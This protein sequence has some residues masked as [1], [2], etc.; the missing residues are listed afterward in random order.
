[1]L[2]GAF[3]HSALQELMWAWPRLMANGLRRDDRT[4]ASNP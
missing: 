3:G 4:Q 1:V 2:Y